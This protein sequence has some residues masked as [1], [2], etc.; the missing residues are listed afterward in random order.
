MTHTKTKANK[1]DPFLCKHVCYSLLHRAARYTFFIFMLTLQAT[2]LPD[3]SQEQ[4]E[5]AQ[6][7]PC[8]WW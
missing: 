6:L 4:L 2:Y 8:G 1:I 3:K 5:Y 7:E